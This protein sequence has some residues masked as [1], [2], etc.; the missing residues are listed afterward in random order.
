MS[1]GGSG[2]SDLGDSYDVTPLSDGIYTA[3]SIAW[4]AMMNYI[5]GSD[6]FEIARNCFIQAAIDLYGSCSDEVL[7][8]AE[9]FNAVG[10]AH[11]TSLNL[12][13]MCGT[14][15]SPATID[16]IEGV[17]NASINN[18]EFSTSCNTTVTSTVTAKSGNFVQFFPGF[19]ASSGCTFTAYISPCSS[20]KYDPDN[21]RISTVHSSNQ[22]SSSF[23]KEMNLSPNPADEFTVV[24]IHNNDE[25]SSSLLILD[26]TGKIEQTVFSDFLIPKDAFET[27][28]NT[29]QLK[30]GI[31]L[32]V[33]KSGDQM[34]SQKFVVD[35]Q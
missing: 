24:T 4:Q 23:K 34:L 14:Y 16:A 18:Y 26:M 10:V 12:A 27:K 8:V 15:S 22:T 9:A 19:T 21:L 20:S 31:Y 1:E 7:T 32:C 6:D 5:D 2:T 13:S 28:I 29:S 35:H 11:Y 3:E 33:L 30:P 25:S 17:A